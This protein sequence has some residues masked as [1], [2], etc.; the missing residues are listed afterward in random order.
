MQASELAPI[1]SLH[2][3]PITPRAL[4]H[5]TSNDALRL[6]YTLTIVISDPLENG[7]S[8]SPLAPDPK[9][10]ITTATIAL[11]NAHSFADGRCKRG[12]IRPRTTRTTARAGGPLSYIAGRRGAHL[13][14]KASAPRTIR[15]LII[16]VKTKRA[17]FFLSPCSTANREFLPRRVISA[18]TEPRR[19]SAWLRAI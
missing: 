9:H 14:A 17:S 15:K 11:T 2:H 5:S 13:P 16:M 12:R 10:P 1:N 3:A 19:R 6:T 8:L 7:N 4:H 18:R